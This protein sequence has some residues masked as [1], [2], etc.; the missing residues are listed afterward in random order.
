MAVT[1][2]FATI[3][4]AI[5]EIREGRFVVVVDDP[6]RGNEG[7]LAIAAPFAAPEALNF[8]VTHARGQICLCL[9]EAR[10][11]EL[12]LRLIADQSRSRHGTAYTATIDARAEVGR[13]A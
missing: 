10:A 2:P 6:D 13:A 12:G 5:E 3:E 1:T 7:D 4:Q 11:D 9:A 8:M